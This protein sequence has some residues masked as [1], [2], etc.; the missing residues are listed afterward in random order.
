MVLAEAIAVLLVGQIEWRS[1]G[2]LTVGMAVFA[3]LLWTAL[4]AAGVVALARHLLVA[5]LGDACSR[6]EAARRSVDGDVVTAA[7]TLERLGESLR[8][9]EAPLT[10]LRECLLASAGATKPREAAAEM[11]R[12][13]RAAG[14]AAGLLRLSTESL[15]LV[16]VLETWL[17]AARSRQDELGDRTAELR[18]RL[19]HLPAPASCEAASPDSECGYGLAEGAPAASDD[20]WSAL[21]PALQERLRG[22]SPHSRDGGAPDWN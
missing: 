22:S 11:M 5:G 4:L 6:L 2:A 19:E 3:M 13:A 16:D 20:A 14:L 10:E 15:R 12:A 21:P 1:A 8:R 9:Q 18:E 17:A 7:A